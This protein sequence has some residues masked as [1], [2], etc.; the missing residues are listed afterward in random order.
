VVAELNKI[1]RIDIMLEPIDD[2]LARGTMAKYH[3]TKTIL[4]TII[5]SGAC[6]AGT[7]P[8]D[9]KLFQLTGILEVEF[10]NTA[11]L[12]RLNTMDAMRMFAPALRRGLSGGGSKK[13][14]S[15]KKKK[16]KSKR[17]RSKTRRRRR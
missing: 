3:K 13:R 4:Q 1:D 6:D 8:K 9:N 12:A 7:M 10:A 17:K 14:K 16:G 5:D 2:I 15:K 11:K